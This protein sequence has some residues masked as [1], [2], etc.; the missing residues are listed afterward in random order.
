[1]TK[2]NKLKRI[3]NLLG[4]VEDK[5]SG[6]FSSFDKGVAEMK[7]R[8]KEDITVSTLSSVEDKLAR[9][10]KLIDLEPLVQSVNELQDALAGGFTSISNGVSTELNNALVALENTRSDLTS[11][12]SRIADELNTI[13]TQ[14]LSVDAN[15]QR[16]LKEKD[17][18]IKGILADVTELSGTLNGLSADIEELRGE[19]VKEEEVSPTDWD[20]K[21]EKLRTELMNRVNRIHVGGGNANR[22]IAIGG[23]TS[24][25]STYTDINIKPGTGITLTYAN[26]TNTKYLDLTITSS[27]GP[28][29][30]SRS[31]SSVATS[32]TAADTASTDQVY[33]CTAGINL[34]LPTAVANTNLYTVKNTSNSSVL[35]TTTGGQTIDGDTTVIMPI[36]YTSVDIISDDANWHIT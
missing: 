27:G 25:L 7:A 16:T 24:V 1:M 21:L 2:K 36:K 34:T 14:S 10:K 6:A 5:S 13:S 4:D 33:I 32:Q 19:M 22:N 17:A 20:D 12:V 35:V 31:I 18:T 23:N 15:I 11:E 29:G 8:L 30:T 3:A 26:N 28:G 9:F